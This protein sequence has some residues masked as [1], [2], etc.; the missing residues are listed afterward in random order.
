M[1]HKELQTTPTM[2]SRALAAGMLGV[3]IGTF[4]LGQYFGLIGP[5][6]APDTVTAAERRA[7]ARHDAEIKHLIAAREARAAAVSSVERAQQEAQ[8][9][10]IAPLKPVEA[11]TAVSAVEQAPSPTPRNTPE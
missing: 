9:V 7:L 11:A 2:L 5:I 6:I 1:R 4:L 8:V 10:R 3:I